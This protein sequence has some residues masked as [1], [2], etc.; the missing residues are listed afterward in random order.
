MFCSYASGQKVF[1]ASL[2]L[3]TST[4]YTKINMCHPMMVYKSLNSKTATVCN[5]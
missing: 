4:G 5:T 2:I 1:S 3:Q